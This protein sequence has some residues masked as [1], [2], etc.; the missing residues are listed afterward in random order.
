MISS[1]CLTCCDEWLMNVVTLHNI[2]SDDIFFFNVMLRS[3]WVLGAGVCHLSLSPSVSVCLSLPLSRRSASVTQKS[4][5]P[6][7]LIEAQLFAPTP[8]GTSS[9]NLSPPLPL[10]S[11]PFFQ[12]ICIWEIY[13]PLDIDRGLGFH[14]KPMSFM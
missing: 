4:R 13:N 14:S 8:D 5:K 1:S 10:Y 6:W 9:P 2:I 11:L 12:R 7:R 3:L